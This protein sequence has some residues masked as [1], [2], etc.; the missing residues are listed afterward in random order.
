MN[1]EISYLYTYYRNGE[2]FVTTNRD[3]A[4]IRTDEPDNITARLIV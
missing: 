2:E 3:V 4:Y 1:Q